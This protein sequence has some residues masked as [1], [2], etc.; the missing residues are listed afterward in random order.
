MALPRCL[1][2]VLVF[3]FWA[4]AQSDVLITG[5]TGRT[6]SLLY[7]ILKG[8]RMLGQT[9]ALVRNLTVAR[10]KLGCMRCDASE[11]IFVGD[12]TDPA[13]LVPALNGVST[14]AIAVGVL[15]G[16]ESV[17]KA[18]EWLGVKNQVEV[19]LKHGAAGK[20]VALISTMGTTH[21]GGPLGTISFYKLNAE[22]FLAS[23]G[24]PFSIIKP[25]GLVDQPEG[26]RELLVGHDDEASGESSGTIPRA[27]VASVTATALLEPPAD[28]MRFDLCAKGPGS[29]PRGPLRKVLEEAL[30][31]WQRPSNPAGDAATLV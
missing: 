19:L 4:L 26:D 10:E 25:C 28:V 22:A 6:G 3:N 14:L 16:D 31:P 24:V 30:L 5:A 12:V 8:T 13:S 29:G 20:R 17:I 7:K 11:G 18:V 23:A 27:D 15:G 1:R 21:P 2:I 9:R